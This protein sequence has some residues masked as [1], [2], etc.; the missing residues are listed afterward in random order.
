VTM[1]LAHSQSHRM[2]RKPSSRPTRTKRPRS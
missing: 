1:L 2:A